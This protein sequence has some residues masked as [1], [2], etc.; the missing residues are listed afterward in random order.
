MDE[1]SILREDS[2]EVM[3]DNTQLEDETNMNEP[4][5]LEE[6]LDC[7]TYLKNKR[8][9]EEDSTEMWQNVIR[10]HKKK[11]TRNNM[12]TVR[13]RT[14]LT[15]ICVTSK[16]MLPKQFALAKLLKTHEI[17]DIS[18]VKYINPFKL[19]ITFEN[20]LSS[21]KLCSCPVF[22]EMGWRCQKSWEVGI[23]HG[24]LKDIERDI[25]D[26]ELMNNISSEIDIVST[27]RLNRR[28]QDGWVPS[29]SVKISFLGS[30]LPQYIYL[31]GMKVKVEPYIFPV[32]QCSRCWRYGHVAKMC[33]SNKI[34]CPKCGKSH[35]NCDTTNFTCV[36]CNGDHMALA[37]TCPIFKKEKR[38]RELMSEYNCTYRR[39]LTL[40]VPPSPIP[41]RNT[42]RVEQRISSPLT[43]IE[44]LNTDLNQDILGAKASY[45]SVT[46]NVNKRSNVKGTPPKTSR[47]KQL[48]KRFKK[49]VMV[50]NLNSADPEIESLQSM[51]D[52]DT[53]GG[54]QHDSKSSNNSHKNEMKADNWSNLLN[55]I[56]TIIFQ[57][58]NSI[59]DKI[60]SIFSAFLDC[61]LTNFYKYFSGFALF[62]DLFSTQNE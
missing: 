45:A 27:R 51:S 60:K 54:S 29:E 9:R 20:I 26:E 28:N 22:V 11:N 37:K 58:N 7:D 17:Q 19:L 42:E 8:G 18:R 61:L 59:V 39:A 52:V 24:V 33:P 36:N 25:S 15:Q 40:Y 6:D 38:I 43:F 3:V 56:K 47:K 12:H 13:L 48:P 14:E 1:D 46:K 41:E 53:S 4:T 44:S 21:E 57:R 34:I 5:H 31:F 32:T 2:L 35:A 49:N 50:N 55:I 16:Q 30:S 23:S 62:N 10:N